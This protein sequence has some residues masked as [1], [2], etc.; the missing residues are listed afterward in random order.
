MKVIME[1]RESITTGFD[2]DK[3]RQRNVL[4]PLDEG[5]LMVMPTFTAINPR[6]AS[7]PLHDEIRLADKYAEWTLYAAFICPSILVRPEVCVCVQMCIFFFF[8]F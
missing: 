2:S 6:L 8:F 5:L 7:V 3:L 1:L 4:N